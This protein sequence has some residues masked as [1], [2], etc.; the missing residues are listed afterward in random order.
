VLKSSQA[1]SHANIE[2]KTGVSEISTA[3]INSI[4]PDDENHQDLRNVCFLVNND[5]VDCPRRF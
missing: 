4:I 2:L 3:S 5:R 1:I